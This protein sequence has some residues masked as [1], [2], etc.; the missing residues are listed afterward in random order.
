[1]LNKGY[2]TKLK[3]DAKSVIL[4]DLEE[5]QEKLGE[6]LKK[7]LNQENEHYFTKHLKRIFE[8]IKD[9]CLMHGSPP[10][11]LMGADFYQKIELFMNY[12][13]ESYSDHEIYDLI[14]EV[15]KSFYI[16]FILAYLEDEDYI[17]LPYIGKIKLQEVMKYSEFHKEIVKFYYGVIRLDDQF[18]GELKNI[19]EGKSSNITDSALEQTEK[20]LNEKIS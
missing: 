7:F 12:D 20:I 11:L 14:C 16:N 18:R 10:K 4:D 3:K 6:K 19:R 13:R 8:V 9:R 1:M 5:E 15:F 2:S 17:P